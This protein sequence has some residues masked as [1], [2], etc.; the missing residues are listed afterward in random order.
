MNINLRIPVDTATP[1]LKK[2]LAAL[3]PH[4]VASRIAP[5][6]AQYWRDHLASLPKNKN[7]YPSTG[8][9]EDAARRIV[10]IAMEFGAVL[11]C[12][13]LGIRQR[14][15][16]GTIHAVKN[17]FLSIPICSEAY[18][19]TPKDWGKSLVPVRLS[20]GRWFLA[21]WLGSEITKS[22]YKAAK[23]GQKAKRAEV[24]TRRVQQFAASKIGEKPS[25][26]IFKQKS[27]SNAAADY[28]RTEKHLNLKFLFRLKSEVHQDPNPNVLPPD[29]R[30]RALEEVRKAVTILSE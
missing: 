15:Y 14:L 30:E 6:L 12:N 24:S 10:G 22:S 7:G 2:Q 8:F 3:D 1:L 26:I 18:G 23:I 29:L 9:W 20:D 17:K 25:V 21:L 28:Q 13:K 5:P 4:K 19:T 11:S 27:G 16:G